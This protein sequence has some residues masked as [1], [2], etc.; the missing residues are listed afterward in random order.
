MCQ[1]YISIAYRVSKCISKAFYI[2][3]NIKGRRERKCALD[4]WHITFGLSQY[5]GITLASGSL[6]HH[7]C[8]SGM[9]LSQP[10]SSGK[11]GVRGRY[12]AL[13][14]AKLHVYHKTS[15]HILSYSRQVQYDQKL[16][17]DIIK[18]FYGM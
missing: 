13:E 15:S 12:I 6:A 16:L 11:T 9:S 3:N 5:N 8:I 2:Q 10:S 18:W 14:N 17:S 7:S 1:R 4:I